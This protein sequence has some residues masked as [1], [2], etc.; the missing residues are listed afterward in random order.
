MKII[1]GTLKSRT[2]DSPGG[3]R[4]HPMSDKLRGAI[5]NALGDIEGLTVLDVFS[6]SGA[7]AFEAISRGAKSAVLIEQD[8]R[9]VE[10]IRRNI[11]AL[12]LDDR[13][14]LVA[15]YARSWSTRHKAQKFN[16][17]LMD[18]PFDN[19]QEKAIGRL[20]EHLA[21]G[22]TLVLNFPA[23][24]RPPYELTHLELVKQKVHGAARLLFYKY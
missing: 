6:G 11:T 13:V 7:L 21:L 22:G 24:E 9:A 1:S 16:L 20:S 3:H 19:L 8:K 2:F 15:A 4:T 5:F 12:Q 18:P 17:V 23:N 14:N 10:T